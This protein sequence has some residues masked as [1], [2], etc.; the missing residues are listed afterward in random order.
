M[1]KQGLILAPI[2]CDGMILQRDKEN[3]IYGTDTIAETVTVIFMD[4]EYSGAVEENGDFCIKLPKISAGGPYNLI[5]KGSE[6]ISISDILFGDVY[7]LT[8]QSNME[9]PLRRVLDVSAEEISQTNEPEIRQYLLPAAYQFSGPKKYMYASPWKKAQGEDLMGFSAVGYFFAKEIKDTY[10]VPVGLILAAVGGSRIEAWMS[11]ASVKKFN[12]YNPIVEEFY[13]LDYFN[14]YMNK[15]QILS[16]KWLKE[17]EEEEQIV[18]NEDM[19]NWETCVVPSLVSD[20][21]DKPFQGAVYI[22]REI[23]LPEEPTAGSASI[24][25]GTIIDSDCIWING[26]LIGRTEYRYPPRKYPIPD[27]VLKKGSNL[28]LIRIV[29]NKENGGTIKGRPYFLSCN[30]KRVSLAGEWHYRIGKTAEKP[31]PEML[32]PTR[33]PTGLY[34]T[35]IVPMSK[36]AFKGMLWYQGESNTFD[37]SGYS[38]KFEQ[39]LKDLRKLLGYDIPCIYAQLPG[40]QEPLD[41]RK[42]SGWAELRHQQFLNLSLKQ[43]AMAVTLDLGEYNDLH[44]QNKKAVS[45][46][47]AKAARHLIYGEN[48][49]YSGPVLKKGI[50]KDNQVILEFSHLEHTE[51]EEVLSNFELAGID[52]MY[53]QAQA[54]RKGKYVIVTSDKVKHPVCV[55]YAWCDNPTDINFYNHAGIPAP[56]F[57]M[58]L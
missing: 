2:F 3:C 5:V 53:Y 11:P 24:Y 41:N 16:D 34:H 46:R 42:D 36:A 14:E 29:I 28:I 13:D 56:G 52:L 10:K 21:T 32:F 50:V 7:F 25:M 27:G 43:T 39:M 19:K 9:L 57:R 12:E 17:L 22:C 45:I 47:M 4:R 48:I 44:P 20:Y 49:E 35:A 15:Q 55:R 26:R 1:D 40:Y 33:L 23:L 51:E 8:G 31:M 58:E 38:D 18:T 6:S 30:N 54:V 37:P